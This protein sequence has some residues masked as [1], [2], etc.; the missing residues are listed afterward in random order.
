MM[1]NQKTVKTRIYNILL[2]ISF[3]GTL[4]FAFEIVNMMVS[5]KYETKNPGD[6]ISLVNGQNICEGITICKWLTVV[7]G[8]ITIILFIFRKRFKK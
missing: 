6:C 3:L 1:T 7:F 4:F 2:T 5:L 8:L